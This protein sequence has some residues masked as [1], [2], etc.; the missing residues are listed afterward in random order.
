[1]N[2]KYIILPTS[3]MVALNGEPHTIHSSHEHFAEIQRMLE[4]GDF[5]IRH[6]IDK[7]S[8]IKEYCGVE[9]TVEAGIVYFNDKPVQNNITERIFEMY[10]AGD[11][12]SALTN[13]LTKVA[14]NPNPL[15]IEQIDMF[16]KGV[17]I[18]IGKDGCLYAYKAIQPDYT[19][20]YSGTIN[21]SVGTVVSVNREDVDDDNNRGCSHGLHCGNISY[22][23]DYGNNSR[24]RLVI[25]RVE[26]ENIVS[27][28]KDH[29]FMKVRCCEYKVVS[30]VTWDYLLNLTVQS[31]LNGDE[32]LS[33]AI[34]EVQ[35]YEDVAEEVAE[36]VAEDVANPLET[37]SGSKW[38]IAEDTVLNNMRVANASYDDIAKVIGRS[39]NACRKRFNIGLGDTEPVTETPELGSKWTVA[40]DKVLGQMRV[41]NA[42]YD[43]ISKVIGRSSNACRK[44]FNRTQY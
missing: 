13:F 19:D 43:V 10:K 25:V 34:D 1:M 11:D 28:P 29:S 37:K 44:R 41:V 23:R 22:V 27:V 18:P 39:A 2:N 4:G 24:N 16:L 35:P 15:I 32:V 30:E 42:S 9:V 17:H 12:I 26:P 36:D 40:E 5:D 31:D 14:K 33:I 38:S 21:N 20:I 7:S 8:V 6:L 3:I